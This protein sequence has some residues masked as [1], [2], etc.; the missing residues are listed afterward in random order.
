MFKIN[1]FGWSD[2]YLQRMVELVGPAVVYDIEVLPNVFTLN[3]ESIDK[4]DN[5]TFEISDRRNDLGLLLQWFD[6]LNSIQMPMIG[7]NNTGYDYLIIHLIWQYRHA[8]TYQHLFQ[9]NEQ[10]IG[11]NER[12][13]NMVWPSD[14]FTPQIDL[15]KIHHFDNVA[16][17]QDLKS[18]E[19]NMRS[20]SVLEG[21]VEFGEYL[22]HPLIDSELIPYNCHD[23]KETKKFALVSAEAIAFRRDMSKTLKG[24]VLNFNE[25]KIGKELLI[26]RLGDALCYD[27]SSGRKQPRQSFRST[28][29]LADVIFPYISFQHP[30]MNRVLNWM[31]SQTLTPADLESEDQ[32]VSTKGVFTGVNAVIDGFQ[33]D[34]GTGGI[35]GSVNGLK[36]VA[37]DEWHI[38]DIDVTGLYPSIAIKNR[39]YPEHLGEQF[40]A[41]Y[42]KL[43]EERAKYKKGTTQNAA[44]KLGQNGAYGD[45]NNPY[46]P[47]YDPKFTMTITINGQLML[48]M[49]AE[50]LMR[51]P[52]FQMIQINTDG[53]TYRIHHTMRAHAEAIQAEWERF[54]LLNLE[55]ASYKRMWVRDVNNYVAESPDGKLKLKGD[56]WY[57]D[58]S[59]YEGG[60]PEAI[61]KAGPSAWHKDLGAQIVQRAAVAAMVHGVDPE[62]F[63]RV[64]RDPF[65]FMLRAKLQRG[66]ELFI[67]DQQVQRITRYYITKQGG[68]LRKISPPTGTPGQYKKARG[69]SD[70]DYEAWHAAWGNV[71]N[72]DLH[73][74]NKSIH[75]ERETS[76][77]S[78]WLVSECN[79]A[80]DFDFDKLNLQW[81]LEGARKLII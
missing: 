75:E 45:S 42:G 16:K 2:E 13:G 63:M 10:I 77:Q 81:Y 57:P 6:H 38:D 11:S 23:V 19:F 68:P 73:T 33:F 60:W 36:Y 74:K 65:D 30:E 78:G 26:Q 44:I 66:S 31:K 29:P 70:R 46:S 4:D 72:P 47:L 53:M 8:V 9:K 54:T 51:L 24:D 22:A 32:R 69:A 21:A 55:H 58:G 34:F 64:H 18:L 79:I 52:T 41:E 76:L 39:L 25:T 7:F 1:P 56:Y 43:P 71:W 20:S 3:A 15:M 17:R 80:T 35:H 12:F 27:R 48:C 61:S 62:T 40:I 14:W 49:L 67:G 37:D 50:R 28:I 59:K 5:Y